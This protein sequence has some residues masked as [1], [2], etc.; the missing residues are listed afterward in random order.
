MAHY[1]CYLTNGGRIESAEDF[2][3]GSDEEAVAK[4]RELH[5]QRRRSVELWAGTR[6]V[7]ALPDGGTPAGG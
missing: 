6:R 7:F 2:E 4:A 3:C 5:E 1:R